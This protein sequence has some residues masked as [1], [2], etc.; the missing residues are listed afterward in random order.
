[1]LHHCDV[2]A[3][4]HSGIRKARLAGLSRKGARPNRSADAFPHSCVIAES[5]NTRDDNSPIRVGQ[6]AESMD[7]KFV[8]AN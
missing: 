3:D 8:A 1:M 7:F 4:A 5:A 2:A 6:A